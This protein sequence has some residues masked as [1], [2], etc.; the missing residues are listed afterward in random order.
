MRDTSK[1]LLSVVAFLF[2]FS[3]S[4][5]AQESAELPVLK[6]IKG[7]NL[8]EELVPSQHPKTKLWGYANNEGKFII[9]PL[10][11]EACPYEGNLARIRIAG[12]W[13]ALNERGLYKFIP[14]FDRL[15]AYSSDS[16]AI[17]EV[18]GKYT[19]VNTKGLSVLNCEYAS[20]EYADYGYLV[21]NDGLYGTMN[22][23]GKIVLEPQFNE[24]VM[25]DR[26][27]VVEHVMKDGRWG[28]MRNGAE[29]SEI[30]WTEKVSFFQSGTD[31]YPDLYLAVHNGK[32]GVVTLRGDYVV[33]GIYDSIEKSSSGE[34]YITQK[35]G[36]Y[37]ALTFK[38]VEFIPPVLT[39]K[40][41]IGE[42][43]FKIHDAG[44][45]FC[46]NVNGS[47]KFEDCAD[48]YS[49]FKPEEYRTTKYLPQW[50][51]THMIEENV[52]ARQ[53]RLDQARAI[54]EGKGPA[55][56][57][58]ISGDRTAKYGLLESGI[59]QGTSGNIDGYNVFY[60]AADGTG[61]NIYLAVDPSKS[62]CVLRVD[63]VS[64][65]IN[66][67]VQ[68]F[69]I[70]KTL[71]MYPKGYARISE[72]KVLLLMAFVRNQDEASTSLI[73]TNQYMLP[74]ES[75]DI[76][77][78]NGPH[79]ARKESHA[80]LT[81]STESSSAVS[82]I[83]LSQNT[84]G[85][86]HA[87]Q[88]GGF[89][90]SGSSSIL[91]D[92]NSPLRRFDSN[93][94]LDWE[95]R[96]YDGEVFFDM[97]ETE[98]YIYLCGAV[99]NNS[100]GAETPLLVKLSK[101]GIEKGRK[102]TDN[103]NARF[104]GLICENNLLYARLSTSKGA[105]PSGM[106]YY[107]AF[108]LEDMGDNVGVRHACV[109]N[110]WGTGYVGGLGLVDEKGNWLQTPM[111]SPDQMCATFDWEFCGFAGNHLIVRHMGLY[112]LVDRKGTMVV[113]PKYDQLESMSDPGCFKARLNNMY[114]VIDTLGR[115]LIPL[116]FSYVGSMNEGVIV[117]SRNGGYGC[118]DKEYRQLVPME[119]EEIR[120]YAS[121]LARIKY[122]GRFGF[123]DKAGEIIIAPFSDEVDDFS[124][125]VVLVVI[126][127]KKGFVNS[128]GNWVTPPMY[129]DGGRFSSGL[130]YV[131]MAG[132]YGYVDK[133]GNIAIPMQFTAAKDFDMKTSLACVAQDGKWGVIDKKGLTILPF[134][135]DSV[136][137]TSDG[138]ICVETNG[139]SGIYNSKGKEVFPVICDNIE[140]GNDGVMFKHGVVE[141][142]LDGQ[143][144]RI[145]ENGNRV[146][147][148]AL[149]KK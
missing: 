89:Y 90:I 19:L 28:L 34:Y 78:Y 133:T 124:E 109:W 32:Y 48:L 70:K 108:N 138:Y 143:R 51:K 105:F 101:R 74:V 140:I 72:N 33:P 42:N 95:Y 87:S 97:E 66:P 61:N 122:K 77:V 137:I 119:Y 39:S 111:L 128:K 27:N 54:L 18:G 100:Q 12:K 44:K 126:K 10:F 47:I 38:M 116:E 145:D 46:A 35:D 110:E 52:L 17:A 104:V 117:V 92:S 112:G 148:Y 2:V 57:A 13:G 149:L 1:T 129:D 121:G 50:A 63:D 130:A 4:L 53:T 37:G 85:R 45:F 94:I 43:I 107:P 125:G 83:E 9:K 131:S 99:K 55:D 106:D 144:I 127:N 102:T 84:S 81:M 76:K 3:A 118:Y 75:Y 96:P 93:G 67:I 56:A 60:K 25:L 21:K 91:A 65:P 31:G 16:L 132:K 30:K 6:E 103:E 134:N 49:V 146:F 98:N 69:N 123:I 80:V 139:R 82:M 71:G 8:Q 5:A 68:K 7:K 20:F 58:Y 120:E 147:L 114:G 26:S 142:N 24:V 22:H 62:E 64:I 15:D 23:K 88:F 29:L 79:D 59:F 113:D 136:R 115:V 135:Y 40:P 41:F 73:E 141:A 14:R 86:I 11:E 36:H